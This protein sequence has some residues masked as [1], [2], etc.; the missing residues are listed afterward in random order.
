MV[1]IHSLLLKKQCSWLEYGQLD[2][3]LILVLYVILLPIEDNLCTLLVCTLVQ[4]LRGKLLSEQ[5]RLKREVINERCLQVLDGPVK[6]LLWCLRKKDNLFDVTR[7]S[8]AKFSLNEPFKS[9]NH[10]HVRVSD[11]SLTGSDHRSVTE[12]GRKQTHLT[13]IDRYQY[14]TLLK[15]LHVESWVLTV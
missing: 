4:S 1:S 10:C 15:G 9:L 12:D 3:G 14:L 6:C 8:F 2:T 5:A 11:C 13:L 7:S